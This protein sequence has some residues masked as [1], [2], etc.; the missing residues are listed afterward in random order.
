M[1]AFFFKSWVEFGVVGGGGAA[2][3]SENDDQSL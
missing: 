3:E 1:K 2:H